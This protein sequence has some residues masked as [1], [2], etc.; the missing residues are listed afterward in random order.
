MRLTSKHKDNKIK[1]NTNSLS[2][3]QNIVKEPSGKVMNLSM[4][5][6]S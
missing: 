1:K 5:K 3:F 2:Q 6:L 4:A